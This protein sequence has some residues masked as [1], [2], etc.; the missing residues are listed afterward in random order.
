MGSKSTDKKLV[1]ILSDLRAS[2]DK[3]VAHA[4]KSLEIHGS[5]DAVRPIIDRLAQP[6]SAKNR[7][8]LFE[9]LCSLK[10]SSC[11]VEIMDLLND[12]AY[13][14]QKLEILTAIW[15]MKVDF[16]DYV[17]EFVEIAVNGDFMHAL[18]CLTIIENMEGP[19]LEEDILESQ[20]HLKNY[21]ES[22][23][24]SDQQK[25][26]LLSEIAIRIKEINESLTD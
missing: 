18:E 14:D 25:A 13:E 12:P 21:L 26:Q 15:N 22:E 10:D 5:A 4:I 2:D 24:K 11:R 19:F 8:D 16:S 3:L 17:A 20:L 9:L 7:E 1:Q 6:L 23:K